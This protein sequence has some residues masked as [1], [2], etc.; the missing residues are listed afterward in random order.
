LIIFAY[1]GNEA[2]AG[3]P[4]IEPFVQQFRRL[5]R[6]LKSDENRFAF[7]LPPD[8]DAQVKPYADAATHYNAQVGEYRDAIR[9]LA[10]ELKSPVIDLTKPAAEE[11]QLKDGPTTTD[12]LNLTAT[13]Y[14]A[15]AHRL[16]DQFDVPLQG[17]TLPM[18]AD[19]Y[20][21]TATVSSSDRVE[22]MRDEIVRKNELF[23]HRWRPQNFTYLFGFR[24][25]EQGN[26]SVEI[27]QFDPL[28]EKREA[29]IAEL[30]A[31]K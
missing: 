2:S 22:R 25:Y 27:P 4:G 3:H 13:G 23:F 12:G 7:L 14:W 9:R 1:G 19:T 26:N 6:D 29:A 15:L 28:I 11:S 21:T 20:P 10:I 30:R 5:T 16:R 8:M 24:K 31:G 17:V 18:P